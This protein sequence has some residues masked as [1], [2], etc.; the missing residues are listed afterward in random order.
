ML[1]LVHNSTKLHHPR[2]PP[3]FSL[4]GIELDNLLRSFAT[5][6]SVILSKDTQSLFDFG[7]AT[8]TSC[9]KGHQGLRVVHILEIGVELE[10]VC[11]LKFL[12]VS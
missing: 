12:C 6:E 5:Y 7:N 2:E 10:Q 9:G 3:D 8:V 11:Y 4:Q 1:F